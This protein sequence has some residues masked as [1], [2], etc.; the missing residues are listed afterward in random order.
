[1]SEDKNPSNSKN[2]AKKKVM[3]LLALRAHS[4]EELRTKLQDRLSEEEAGP[5]AIEEAIAFAKKNNWLQ[6]PAELSVQTAEQ[7]HRRGKGILYINQY[8]GQKGLPDVDVDQE[9]ELEKALSIVKNKYVENYEF[10]ETEKAKVAR[11][12]TSRGFDSETVGKVIY[13]KL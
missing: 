5:D 3:D 10:S 7:L 8:L 11:L 1:M 6:D 9:L 12:L 2:A 13:E 4:E